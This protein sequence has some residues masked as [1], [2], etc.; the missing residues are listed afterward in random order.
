MLLK[1]LNSNELTQTPYFILDR[2]SISPFFPLL[3]VL[4][5]LA[6]LFSLQF[7]SKALPDYFLQPSSPPRT[8][9]LYLATVLPL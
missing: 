8:H 1:S 5:Q 3:L 6:T 4:V 2:G 7:S 9:Q